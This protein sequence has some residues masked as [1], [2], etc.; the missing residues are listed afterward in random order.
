LRIPSKLLLT[1]RMFACV[2][3]DSEWCH[4]G[5][6]LDAGW[7]N[8]TN[9]ERIQRYRLFAEEARELSLSAASPHRERYADYANR[10]E[11][12]AEVTERK[13]NQGGLNG[14]QMRGV[15]SRG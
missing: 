3:T 14:D 12:L 11:L 5:T 4:M 9:A 10:W 13:T 6:R 8:L 15:T 2:E 1:A 7:S